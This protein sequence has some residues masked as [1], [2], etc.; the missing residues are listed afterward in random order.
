MLGLYIGRMQNTKVC[1]KCCVELGIDSFRVV[2][3]NLDGSPCRSAK[4]KSCLYLE[5]AEY[6]RD[7]SK[8]DPQF[9]ASI[10]KRAFKWAKANPQK[11]SVIAR[12]RNKKAKLENPEKV[13]ARALVN[14]RVRFGRMPRVATLICACG[15]QAKHYH[16]HMGYDF[17]NRYNVIPVCLACHRAADAQ[18]TQ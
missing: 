11:R 13:S 18:A 5:N 17:A 4:C 6:V 14:Q 12:A 3:L 2:K 9:K 1:S 7:R 10:S 16:H 15:A 8:R